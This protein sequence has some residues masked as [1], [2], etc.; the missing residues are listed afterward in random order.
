MYSR[1]EGFPFGKQILNLR[2]KLLNMYKNS[3]KFEDMIFK[4]I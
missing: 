4:F 3:Q 1:K 2:K